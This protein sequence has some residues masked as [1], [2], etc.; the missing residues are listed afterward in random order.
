MIASGRVLRAAWSM[1]V[2]V[3]GLSIQTAWAEDAKSVLESAQKALGNPK[4][5]RF[6]GSGMNAFFGETD[7]IGEAWPK[8][9]L[10]SVTTEIDFD[11][12]ALRLEMNFT[13]PVFLGKKQ[14]YFVNGD[15]AWSLGPNA[16]NTQAPREIPAIE[17]SDVAEERQLKIWMTPHGFVRA[18]LAA[19]N[20]TLRS[21]TEN[22]Q[23][24][25]VVSFTVLNKFKLDGTIDSQGMVTKVETK[26]PDPV[27]G[28]M[29]YVF[30]YSDYKDFGGVK[31]PARI[32]Q[33]A[34]GFEV[35]EFNITSVE[36]NAALD[37]KIPPEIAATS[38]LPVRA[39]SKKLGDGVWFVGGGPY[40]SVV[41]EFSNFITV[42]EAPLNEER[43]LAVIAEAK[44][45][46]PNKPIR[47]V[48]NTHHHFDHAGGLRTYVAQGVTVVTHAS[49][50]AFFEKSFLAPATVVPDQQSKAHRKPVIQTV[51]DKY[52]IT[53][54]KQ[55]IE[56][57]STTGDSHTTELLFAYIPSVKALV[58][59][60]SYNPRDNNIV[61]ATPPHD[62]LAL[63]D[64]IQRFHLDVATIVGIHGMG[65]V[66]VAKF[67]KWIGKA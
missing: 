44:R 63:Y 45:L 14:T 23:K 54:G 18:G 20:A 46:A 15:K 3:L 7:T 28:D 57:Y 19:A 62:A 40:H 11:Q 17:G 6:S 29:P 67:L 55:S 47:Y 39:E 21:R 51:S 27:L 10:A 33:T 41:V 26:F 37:L 2:P 56:I 4:S 43:S 12:K 35:N 5:V 61:P 53:D 25:K 8:R 36:P 32:V 58:E 24:V 50:K 65:P 49:N 13:E 38:P 9:P 1:V 31:F 48:V 60:D 34:G 52:V 22:G 42:I 59:A 64:N 30:L 66:P 16:M